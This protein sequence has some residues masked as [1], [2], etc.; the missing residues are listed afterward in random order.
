MSAREI[1]TRAANAS[2]LL[3]DSEVD[4]VLVC[5]QVQVE[6]HDVRTFVFSAP[7]PRR[8]HY[9]PGQFLTF[10]FEIDGQ[11][12]HRC[13]TL[14]SSPTRPDR[15]WI[16]VKRVHGGPASNWLHDHL[17]VGDTVRALGPMGDF[18]WSDHPADKCLFLSAGSGVTPLMSMARA[19]HDLASD[20]DI[21]FVHSARS[22][23]DIVFRDEVALMA[24]ARPGFRAVTL[25]ETTPAGA[26]WDGLGGRLDLARLAVIAPD[27]RERE[28]F[29]C[30]P[31][32]YMA[33]V[34]TMLAEAG[35]DMARH[36]AESFDFETLSPT[37]TEEVVAAEASL[38]PHHKVSFTKSRRDIACAEDAFVLNAARAAGMRLPSSCTKGMCG[39]CKSKLVSG[40]VEMTHAG[41][42]RQREI[43]QGLILICCS[44]PTSDLVIER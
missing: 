8:F 17:R 22:P 19:H 5:R 25:C 1:L 34:A 38:V 39:T 23:L 41:G 2:P 35:F 12:V 31:A 4:D 27:F 33:G 13:Y 7:Q 14:A 15:V 28:I 11:T 43:D 36:H 16:T 10:A 42:I 44:R 29:V 37:E 21:V 26:S 24:K 40:T 3:W 30:G 18:T 6:T 20:T 9:K 32:G